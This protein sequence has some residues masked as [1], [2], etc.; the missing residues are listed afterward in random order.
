VPN[1]QGGG[2]YNARVNKAARGY[3]NPAV[4]DPTMVYYFTL[5][6]A[7][8]ENGFAALTS[9]FTPQKS[10]C[11]KTLIHC[12][13]LVNLIE[14]RAY[15]E[16]MGEKEFNNFVKTGKIDM[17]LTYTG[18]PDPRVEGRQT[19]PKTLGYAQN[20]R[21]NTRA[22]LIIGDH[23][24]FV[25]HLAFDGLNVK[26]HSDWRLENAILVDKNDAGEDLFQGHG[27]GRE[28]ERSML[29]ELLEAYNGLARPAV[30]ITQAIN[31]GRQDQ[32]AKLQT[33]YPLVTKERD[34]W[35]VRDP[36][37]EPQRAGRTYD[38]K[39][40]DASNP[41]REPL[42]PGL[43]DPLDMNKLGLVDRPVESAPG[44]APRPQ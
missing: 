12:D 18:F 21:P 20:Y 23:V 39:V 1:D 38:L 36:N 37:R 35:I 13:Y 34:N 30:A 17:W 7:G 9:L 41:E 42:L 5:T 25:N 10:I 19:S 8:R 22:D 6:R 29:T 33:E 16:S 32:Q 3:W 14:F 4:F 43:K 26:Q 24:T 28:V 40:A 31:A 44:R 15:A 2:I 11:D 27:S